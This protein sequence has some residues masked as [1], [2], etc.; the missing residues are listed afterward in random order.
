M[1]SQSQC[2]S[3]TSYRKDLSDRDTVSE[4]AVEQDELGST[5]PLAVNMQQEPGLGKKRK[6]RALAKAPSAPL[7]CF[8]FFFFFGPALTQ[9]SKV[10]QS[11]LVRCELGIDFHRRQ[12]PEI[13]RICFGLGSL[14]ETGD[15]PTSEATPVPNRPPT[16]GRLHLGGHSKGTRVHPAHEPRTPLLASAPSDVQEILQEAAPPPPQ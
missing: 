5:W 8:F 16:C 12:L 9:T 10:G 6:S 11:C 15:Q 7:G 3:V 2:S 13:G 14:Q 4:G 1:H